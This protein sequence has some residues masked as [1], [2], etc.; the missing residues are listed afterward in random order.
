M[1]IDMTELS[2]RHA[3]TDCVSASFEEIVA[4]LADLEAELEGAY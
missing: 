2:V 4:N 3:V 1:P